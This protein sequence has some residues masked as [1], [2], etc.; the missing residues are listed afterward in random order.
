MA[1]KLDV[2]RQFIPSRVNY[3]DEKLNAALANAAYIVCNVMRPFENGQAAFDWTEPSV[4]DRYTM[5]Q[6]SIAIEIL[7]KEG[8]QGQ[9]GHSE[10]SISRVYEAGD[11]SN[12]VLQ[13]I[14]PIAESG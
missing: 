11:I 6:I 9:T 12:T 4:P 5:S 2:L 13:K 1:D 8:A 3:P 14:T 7:A 10:N